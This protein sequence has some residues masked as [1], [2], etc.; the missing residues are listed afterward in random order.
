MLHAFCETPGHGNQQCGFAK[1]SLLVGVEVTKSMAHFCFE[2]TFNL[3][4]TVA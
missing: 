1:A 2:T 4:Q 3:R